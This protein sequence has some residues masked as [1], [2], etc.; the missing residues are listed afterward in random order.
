M[1]PTTLG[2]PA[3]PKLRI[4]VGFFFGIFD[5]LGF[6]FFGEGFL[7]DGKSNRDDRLKELAVGAEAVLDSEQPEGSLLFF[8]I[9]FLSVDDFEENVP[10]GIRLP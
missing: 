7:E 4:R 8:L 3:P 9:V 2:A 6:F 5:G 1:S 10:P